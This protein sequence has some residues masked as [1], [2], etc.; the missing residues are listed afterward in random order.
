MD[1]HSLDKNKRKLND[2]INIIQKIYISLYGLYHGWMVMKVTTARSL[3][4][5]D[6]IDHQYKSGPFVYA[7]VCDKQGT[8][9]KI[10]YDGWFRIIL[11]VCSDFTEE[12]HRFAVAGSISK[13]PAH[14]FKQL[15]KGDFVDVN[16]SRHPGW[17]CSEVV[18]L[19]EESGQVQL[20]YEE[21]NETYLCWSHFDDESKIA[22]IFAKSRN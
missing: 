8:N 15:T 17:K 13:R 16:P 20:I 21:N 14:R 7:T 1:I 3:N 12:L 18:N 9:L 4:V 6:K 2:I 5:D 11:D 19:D 10:H 22:E